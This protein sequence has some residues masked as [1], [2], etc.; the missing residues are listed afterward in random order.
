MSNNAQTI[1]RSK[2]DFIALLDGDDYWISEEKLKRQVEFLESD[3]RY[4]FCFHDGKILKM[5]GT[6]ESF[7]CCGPDHKRH[8]ELKDI[9]C[10]V[11]IPTFS[12]VFRKAALKNYPPDWFNALDAPDRP[13]FLLLAS[14]GP[15]YYINESWAVYRKH[16]QGHWTGRN[17]Q[18]QWMTHL[19][20][21]KVLNRH[22]DLLYNIEFCRCESE[23]L[24]ILAQK[25]LEDGFLDRSAVYFRKY[26]KLNAGVNNQLKVY[27]NIISYRFLQIKRSLL[28]KPAKL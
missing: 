13:L 8:I 14:A 17:Y 7:T 6:F 1:L 2:G 4:V 3:T 23:V 9:I 22:F 12:L 21:Y 28:S 5:D 16:T 11:H 25:L 19:R 10:S 18:S 26:L 24:F 20:I 15:G 27:Q